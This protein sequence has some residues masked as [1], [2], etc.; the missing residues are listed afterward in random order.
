[1]KLLRGAWTEGL[2]GIHPVLRIDLPGQP[3]KQVLRPLLATPPAPK[4]RP[5]SAPLTS[6]GAKTPPTRTP[7]SPA[8]AS[9]TIS[10]PACAPLNPSLDRT[11]SH[12]S[13]IA[14]EEEIYWQAELDR[15]LPHLLLPGKPVRGGGRAVSTAAAEASL[16]LEIERL[17]PLAAALRRRVLRAAARRLGARLSFEA[18]ERL[19]ALLRLRHPAHR[20]PLETARCLTLATVSAP[21]GPL[22]ELR[23][24]RVNTGAAPL[25]RP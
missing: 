21:S 3:P 2:G 11:L 5:T 8:I 6:P 4:S 24:S 23:L 22:R 9:A 12:L 1:M 18:T 13:E 19:L 10:S 16:A 15:L 20:P 7:P 14:R 17:R 25:S